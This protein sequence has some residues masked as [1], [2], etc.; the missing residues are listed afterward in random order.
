MDDPIEVISFSAD[1]QQS[2]VPDKWKNLKDRDEIIYT[3]VVIETNIK[4]TLGVFCE[5]YKTR[6]GR[7][8]SAVIIRRMDWGENAKITTIKDDVI[9]SF[10]RLA[11]ALT[12]ILDSGILIGCL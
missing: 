3:E 8:N 10:L 6:R 11:E 12:P 1:T 2:S 4:K 9:T 5:R 7:W